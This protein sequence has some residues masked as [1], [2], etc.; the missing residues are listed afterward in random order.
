[1]I[2]GEVYDLLFKI[3]LIDNNEVGK[4][5]F[6]QRFTKTELNLESKKTVGVEFAA[7]EVRIDGQLV[8]AQFYCTNDDFDLLQRS[9]RSSSSV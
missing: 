8:K 3:V 7:K 2:P 1:M 5:N 4:S 6:L 9:F